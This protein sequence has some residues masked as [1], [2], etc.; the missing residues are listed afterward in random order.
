[1]RWMVGSWHALACVAFLLWCGLALPQAT[2]GRRIALVIGNDAYDHLGKLRNAEH[3][4]RSIAQALREAGFLVPDK[5]LVVNGSRR[6]MADAAQDFV[7]SIGPQDQVV[8]FF[9]GHGVEV[10]AQA[11]LL[12]VDVRDPTRRPLDG[13]LR[14][15]EEIDTAEQQ[16][17]DDALT[18]NQLA[19]QIAARRP[20]FSLLIVDACRN[21]PVLELMRR[22]HLASPAKAMLPPPQSGFYI[23][24]PAA[25]TQVLLFSASKGQQA[26]DRLSASDPVANSVFTRVLLESLRAKRGLGL[27]DQLAQVSEEVTRLARMR[28]VGG[29]PHVQ[30]PISI[31][32]YDAPNFHLFGAP[33]AAATT[34]P[35]VADPQ[36]A[37]APAPTP[38]AQACAECPEMVVIPAGRFEM[39]S[40]GSEPGRDSDEGPVHSVTVARFELGKFEVT[41]GQW[42]ALMSSDPSRFQDCGDNCPVAGVSWNDVQ[43][44]LHRLK[45]RT[46]RT[47][48]LPSEAEWEYSARAGSNTPYSWGA[49]I[50]RNNA[51]CSACGSR[52]DYKQ[53]A[54]VGSFAP[55]RFGLHDMHGNVREWVQDVWQVSYGGAPSDGSAWM[56][57][58]N[59]ALR[60]LRGGS[61]LDGPQDLRSASRSRGWPAEHYTA[62][63]FRIARTL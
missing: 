35:V 57:G 37:P 41:Q 32:T 9:S 53:P 61:W 63:G 40:P 19:T 26:L 48:R 29:Q 38:V 23:A 58:G 6:R 1:M 30:E 46:G 21:N 15:L 54:P 49:T 50:G 56:A 20:R 10:R 25:R 59:H 60:V 51:N 3:D 14:P 43:D 45:E 42:R 27:R 52:W 11:A 24:Q 8:F 12:P 28:V 5:W 44:Y 55:N 4:A 7:S 2:T 22:A 17:L 18:V 33:T 16:V 13:S 47:Y 34:P 31:A 62:T 39:G 36:P